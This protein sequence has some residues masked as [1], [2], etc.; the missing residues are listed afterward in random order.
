[1]QLIAYALILVFI[2]IGAYFPMD[3]LVK[4]ILPDYITALQIFFI[5]APGIAISSAASVIIYNYFKSLNKMKEFLIIGVLNLIALSLFIYIVFTFVS[6]DILLIAAS[7]VLAQLIWYISLDV[8][9]NKFYKNLS[10]KNLFFI[11]VAS[12]IFYL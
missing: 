1:N 7:T 9:I 5:L 6:E 10:L 8:Y 11:L 3:F 12:T 4:L 2:L